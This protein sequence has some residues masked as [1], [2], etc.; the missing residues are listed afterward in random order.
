MSFVSALRNR[1]WRFFK[2]CHCKFYRK[3]YTNSNVSIISM[4]CTGGVLYHDLGLK[5]LS[6]TVNMYMRAEDFIKF[7]EN[8]NSYL[9]ID[10]MKPCDDISIVGNRK[11]PVAWLGDLLLFLVHY[12]SVE[13]AQEKW[14]ERKSRINRDKIVILDTDR[15]GMTPDLMDRFELLP[16]KKVM[17][18]HKP[19]ENRPSYFHYLPGYETE[20]C[21]GIITDGVGWFG[22]R[23]IDRFDWV[24]FLNEV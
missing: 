1:V 5:F 7:C 19:F 12:K 8:L 2:N 6:P 9:A 14:N 18:I 22:Y 23:P 20:D 17:F 4:N 13:Q 3:R 15:E 16:Y 10:E 21:V 24:G 11:Y